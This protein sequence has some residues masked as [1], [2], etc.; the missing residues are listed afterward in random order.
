MHIEFLTREGCELGPAM[1][2]RLQAA[3]GRGRHFEATDLGRLH[4]RDLRRRYESP[5][6]LVDGED[7]F[8]ARPHCFDQSAPT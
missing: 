6:V 1:M 2:G 4:E 3:L 7:L 5:T 8:G